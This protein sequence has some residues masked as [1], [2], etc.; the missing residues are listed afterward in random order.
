MKTRKSGA[1]TLIELLIVVAIIGILAAIAIPN[2]LQAQ[3]RSKVA[4][5]NADMRTI[6]L[7]L[8]VYAAD[9]GKYPMDTYTRWTYFFPGIGGTHIGNYSVL[10][11]P[12]DYLASIPKDTFPYPSVPE[13]FE[14]FHYKNWDNE[15]GDAVYNYKVWVY[16]G[17]SQDWCIMSIGPDHRFDGADW[18]PV[19]RQYDPTNGTISNGDISRWGP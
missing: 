1:F 19:T 13:E 15:Y 8:E 5:V 14:Y 9:Y 11:T 6:A 7:A 2:F 3:V 10:T 16:E 18:R 12:V 4:R 17:I